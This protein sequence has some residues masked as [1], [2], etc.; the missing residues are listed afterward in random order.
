MDRRENVRLDEADVDMADVDPS[1]QHI[2][3]VSQ[4][5]ASLP[6]GVTA[7]MVDLSAE[8]FEDAI[9]A[10]PM[11]T[12]WRAP[13][14]HANLS[15]FTKKRRHWP[16]MILEKFRDLYFVL[17]PEMRIR[18]I[19][20]TC[21]ELTGHDSDALRSK[22]LHDFVHQDDRAMVMREI[23][24]SIVSGQQFR[25]FYRFKRADSTFAIFESFG[26]PHTV[27]EAGSDVADCGGV[28]MISRPYPT[29][30]ASFLD[31]F[32]GHKIENER[33]QRKIAD[34][35][36]E[37]QE[38]LES[39]DQYWANRDSRSS[40]S[41][42]DGRPEDA[43]LGASAFDG[44]PP[45]PKPG[46]GNAA[47]TKQNLSE[48][49][50]TSRPDSIN[51][52]M[53]RYEGASPTEHIEML[54]GLRSGERSEGISTGAAS[55]ALIMGDAGIEILADRDRLGLENKKKARM[56]E[57]YVCT[58]CGTLESP[59]WRR[60]PSGPKTLCNACGRTCPSFD[61][62]G[63]A[64]ASSAMGQEREEEADS[65][66]VISL[67]SRCERA[68][69]TGMNIRHC[70]PGAWSRLSITW[71]LVIKN[72]HTI[73]TV[74]LSCPAQS[75]DSPGTGRSLIGTTSARRQEPRPPPSPPPNS[76]A[77]CTLPS[78]NSVVHPVSRPS[79]WFP[80]PLF[81]AAFLAGSRD[82]TLS[83]VSSLPRTGATRQVPAQF[84]PSPSFRPRSPSIYP[85]QPT[86]PH[87]H[88]RC[89]PSSG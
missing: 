29:K 80:P 61:L 54:T 89:N 88:C 49:L 84:C 74:I 30:N 9:G 6:I 69:T 52:K 11:P 78:P 48:A 18:H 58:D 35:R 4:M 82:T 38:E 12:G 72:G 34:L 53:A 68:Y 24:E 41:H 67:I 17:S 14:G 86:K 65:L 20:P 15:E 5:A 83:K 77:S 44:M 63:L 45:P 27:K 42:S 73:V 59:E 47:L 16:K 50:A 3:S 32:L 21:E 1:R 37:E 71:D 57:E 31:S 66:R 85:S 36:R 76:L 28:F 26:H 60:G 7:P 51:D 79:A 23:N 19:S 22:V 8:A 2:M 62:F 25:F 13:L 33:L 75:A 81:V 55:P 10:G 64:D 43:E 56:V 40:I 46:V 70:N 87:L 39:Y